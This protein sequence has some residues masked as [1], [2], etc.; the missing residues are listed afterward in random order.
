M[1]VSS[2]RSAASSGAGNADAAGGTATKEK[3][4]DDATPEP[5]LKLSA[6]AAPA[7][8]DVDGMTGNDFLT[9]KSAI[10]IAIQQFINIVGNK[11]SGM[12]GELTAALQTLF[13]VEAVMWAT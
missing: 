8:P 5:T 7:V 10:K 6:V 13:F 2:R 11:T 3:K 4:C 12:L 1:G 9:H